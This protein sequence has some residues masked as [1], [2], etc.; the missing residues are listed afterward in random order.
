MYVFDFLLMFIHF[1]FSYVKHFVYKVFVY[2][3]CFLNKLKHDL[4]FK[5]MN[6]KMQMFQLVKKDSNAVIFRPC[7]NRF[8]GRNQKYTS[9]EFCFVGN[10]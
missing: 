1:V 10:L 3:M 5:E 6:W 2:E 4:T 8:S 7:G 9:M